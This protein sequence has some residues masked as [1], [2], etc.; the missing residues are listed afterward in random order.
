[1]LFTVSNQVTNALPNN[2][3]DKFNRIMAYWLGRLLDWV[4]GGGATRPLPR[5]GSA[6]EGTPRRPNT[7]ATPQGLD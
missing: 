7:Q 3:R 2:Y 4:D 1:V 5:D 6:E